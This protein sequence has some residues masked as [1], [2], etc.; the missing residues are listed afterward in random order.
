MQKFL[1]NANLNARAEPTLTSK[2]VGWHAKGETLTIS[3]SKGHWVKTSKGWVDK[4]S[5][6]PI[7]VQEV[8]QTLV[9]PEVQATPNADAEAKKK[10]IKKSEQVVKSVEED[11]VVTATVSEDQTPVALA[12]TPPASFLV[13]LLIFILA[14]L[15]RFFSIYLLQY[16]IFLY[17]FRDMDS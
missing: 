13:A 3:E 5:L 6:T 17:F 7:A 1:S 4:S 8:V 11:A 10:L 14:F 12:S 16:Q 2:I 9:V 15:L